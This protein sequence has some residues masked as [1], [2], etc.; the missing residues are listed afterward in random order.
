MKYPVFPVIEDTDIAPEFKELK[1]PVFPVIEDTD[2]IPEFKESKYPV[3]PVI[4]DVD[5]TPEFKELKYPIFP[6]IDVTFIKLY[7]PVLDDIEF[8]EIFE[9]PIELNTPVFP[10]ILEIYRLFPVILS[11][12]ILSKIA[13]VEYKELNVPLLDIIADKFIALPVRLENDILFVIILSEYKELNI[14]VFPSTTC[15]S[16]LPKRRLED[17]KL[18]IVPTPDAIFPNCP[19]LAFRNEAPKESKYPS[20]DENE[21]IKALD[22]VIL[23]TLIFSLYNET[24]SPVLLDKY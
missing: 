23:E 6:V 8:V 5:I 3:F 12:L 2:I 18:S 7:I 11:L 19:K 13:S 14:P 15:T 16:T 21:Y 24:N 22:P 10:E 4:E 1:Y 9:D 17:L 20:P